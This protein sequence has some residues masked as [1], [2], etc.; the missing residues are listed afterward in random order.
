MT[1]RTAAGVAA[2]LLAASMLAAC[3]PPPQPDPTASPDTAD[4]TELCA[5]FGDVDTIILNAGSALR[6]GRV[7]EQEYRGWLRLAA[8]ALSRIP[9]DVST[10]VGAAIANAQDVAP[11]TPIGV[12]GEAWD[13]LS[14][15]WGNASFAVR[16][17]CEA[18]GT[19]VVGEAFTG[20]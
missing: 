15:E 7:Q 13:P 10:S 2:L 20:G 5:Q 9:V 3:T 16:A 4:P 14:T 11:A 6:D 19:P 1:M 8:R 18:E 12:V 17:A